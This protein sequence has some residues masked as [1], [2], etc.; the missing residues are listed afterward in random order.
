MVENSYAGTH[1]IGWQGL[2]LRVPE[3]WEPHSLTGTRSEGALQL[4]DGEAIRLRCSWRN[5]KRPPD[6]LAEADSYIER[7]RREARKKKVDFS[8]KRDIP[9]P[10]PPQR[11]ATCFTWRAEETAYAMLLYCQECRRFCLLTVFGRAGRSLEREARGVF[12]GFRC[13]GEGGRERWALFGLRAEVPTGWELVRSGLRAGQV[14][15][16][17]ERG[18]EELALARVA[19][20]RSILRRKKFVRWAE[21]FYGKALRNFLW[22]GRRTEYRGHIALAIEGRERLRSPLVKLWRK[23]RVLR[24]RAWYCRELDKIYAV[25]YAGGRGEEF[26]DLVAGVACHLSGAES[27]EEDSAPAQVGTGGP[28]PGGER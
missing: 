25:W 21:E 28:V 9:F 7:L 14:T 17:F 22:E 20:A 16:E 1:L 13:H 4:D 8:V 19:L 11:A 18:S 24:V 6:L 2:T 5:R 12:S 26:E 27:G 15:L 23:A 10:G 3:L